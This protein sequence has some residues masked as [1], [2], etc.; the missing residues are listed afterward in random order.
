VCKCHG[1]SGSCSIKTCFKALP[2]MRIIGAVLQ[3]RYTAAIEVNRLNSN[4]LDK[5][6]SARRPKSIST[7]SKRVTDDDLIYYTISP[8]YC[9]PDE[10]L[11]SLGTQGRLA[12]HSGTHSHSVTQNSVSQSVSQSVSHS[13]THSVTQSL[14]HSVTQ[15]LT[16]S[17]THSLTN[18]LTHSLTQ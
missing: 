7:P 1:V 8:D 16:H 4:R 14:S 6:R 10:S 12:T 13:V 5:I 18:S 3:R 9:L 15:S 2:S 17:V 11:G